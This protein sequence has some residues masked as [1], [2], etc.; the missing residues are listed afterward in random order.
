MTENIFIQGQKTTLT[1]ALVTVFFA[2]SKAIVGLIS[3]SVVLLGDAIHSFADSF[4]SFAAWFGLKIAK[5]DPTEKFPY[6]FY[7]AE[8]IAALLISFLILFAGYSIIRE[9]IE[10]LFLEYKL[11]IPMV[12][13][14]VALLD[15]IAMFSVGTYELK[16][17]RKIS[18][19]SLIA[20]GRESRMHLF[21][22]S[23]VLIGLVSV[24][25]NIP[26][27]EGIAGIIISLFVFQAGFESAKDAI[28]SLMDVSPDPKIEKKIKE[29]L[30]R[31]SGLR[32]YEN[33]KLRKSGP[34][35]F[36]EVEA[37]IGKS[38]NVKRANEISRKIEKEVKKTI[39]TVDS[40]TV[41]FRPF[42]TKKQKICLPIKE[43]KSLESEISSHFGRAPFLL[44]LEVEKGEIKKSY[45]KENPYKNEKIR[46]GLKVC[47][48]V[49]EEKVDS[50]ITKE[51][52]PI[53]FHTLRD[54]IVDVYKGIDG[55]VEKII[56]KYSQG[57]LSFLETPT[58]KKT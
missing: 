23:V 8:S 25:L 3:G 9:S 11:N 40:F 14:G 10:K 38:I 52:G 48:F 41:S 39:K 27:I 43:D 26:Y 5:K 56:E 32:G 49:I 13:V 34:L 35:V 12:A 21:S 31:I 42:Q 20:D 29:I 37:K 54:N 17:G 47:Q 24:L 16:I 18:S 1:A 53:S 19:Q 50:I 55:T 2:I 44:F 57:K 28:F 58:R 6:G 4:S 46:V 30:N 36:G 15:A 51:M 45:T 33:L 22:S 7:K